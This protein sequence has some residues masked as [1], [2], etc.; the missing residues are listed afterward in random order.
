MPLPRLLPGA[1]IRR[2]TRT[3]CSLSLSL[4]FSFSFSLSLTHSHS[5]TLSLFTFA[6]TLSLSLSRSRYHVLA[7]TLS[8]S[9]SCSL[10]LSFSLS[11]SLA[12]A[13]FRSLSLSR[14]RSR[15]FSFSVML[16]RLIPC[17]I[18]RL[19][20][21]LICLIHC[22]ISAG[23]RG[24][25][26]TVYCTRVIGPVHQEPRKHT[27]NQSHAPRAPT[28][29]QM[30]SDERN[31]RQSGNTTLGARGPVCG[32]EHCTSTL[33]SALRLLAQ[34]GSGTGGVGGERGGGG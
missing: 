12:R 13:L 21:S 25:G 20:V 16:T 32:G 31:A 18:Q 2:A 10:F 4:S 29:L 1:W 34:G 17:T 6:S 30:V 33:R 3:S 5:F 19:Y 28:D 14:A 26:H 24:V 15:S 9:L 27:E 23:H 11:R 7:L 8:L 22:A